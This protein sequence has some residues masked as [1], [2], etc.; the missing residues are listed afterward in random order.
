MDEMKPLEVKRVRT[1]E[2]GARV[3]PPSPSKLKEGFEDEHHHKRRNRMEGGGL[4]WR[5][6]EGFTHER[7]N[8]KMEDSE[9]R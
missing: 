1:D 2:N 7:A 3:T 8:R 4:Y 9:D 6:T 5:P